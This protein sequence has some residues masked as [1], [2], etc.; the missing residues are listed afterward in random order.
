M[1]EPPPEVVASWPKPNY[2]NPEYQGPQLIIL[3]FVLVS[4]SCV[5]VG[6][7]LFVRLHMKKSAGW[8]DW[9]VAA[10]LFWN[11]SSKGKCTNESSRV[12]AGAI[13]NVLTD[14]LVF[15]LPIPTLWKLR[16]PIREKLI[17]VI[18]MSLGLIFLSSKLVTNVSIK[19]T[20]VGYNV[21]VWRTVEAN[22]A[23]ICASIP[24]LRPFARRYLPGMHFKS[25]RSASASSLPMEIQHP[26]AYMQ[27]TLQQSMTAISIDDEETSLEGLTDVYPRAILKMTEVRDRVDVYDFMI[28]SAAMNSSAPE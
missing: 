19:T 23:V 11:K 21:C 25:S 2:V 20:G 6:I 3:G 12:L 17:L 9:L 26:G 16:L 8:D 13:T 24:M 7:R 27:R 28:A 15:A 22:L 10:T 14:F 4:I 5:V 1:R 18:L